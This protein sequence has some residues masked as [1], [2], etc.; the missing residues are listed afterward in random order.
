MRFFDAHNHLQDSRLEP[1]R[2]AILSQLPALGIVQVMVAGSG[3]DD[4]PDVLRLAAGHA[5][6][7]PA[8]GVHPWYVKEQP[9]DWL[10]RLT[11]TLRRHPRATVGEIG[12]DRWVQGHDLAVQLTFFRPQLDL[13]AAL[14]RAATIHC[15]RAWGALHDELRAAS[16]LPQG[17]LLHSYGGPAE[18]VPALTK[19]GAYFSVSPYFLH[20]RKA[21]QLATFQ[22]V[23]IDR[24]LIETDAPD[25][26]PPA[27]INPHPLTAAD[28]SEINH[29]ANLIFLYER[30]AELRG[31]PLPEFSEQIAANYARLFGE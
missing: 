28:G 6:L 14:D 16:R 3:T 18:M 31:M 22:R 27:P 11:Q 7:R 15:L 1:H 21:Q 8:L 9:A 25:M 23:P 29:P 30:I 13:A 24:L 19:L 20:E 10:D 26:W 4:W 12:L 5:F 17:F 2:E